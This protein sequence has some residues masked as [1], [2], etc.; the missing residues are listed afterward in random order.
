KNVAG[1]RAAFE[2]AARIRPKEPLP[3][4]YIGMTYL[5]SNDL[6]GAERSYEKALALDGSVVSAQLGVATIRHLQGRKEEAIQSYERLAQSQ[7]TLGPALNNLAYLYAE[8]GQNLERA[9]ELA[10]QAVTVAPGSGSLRDTLG[11]VLFQRG[12]PTEAIAHL[13]QAARLAPNNPTIQFHLGKALHSQGKT[14]PARTALE[15]A[16]Q[17]NLGGKDREEAESLLR[18]TPRT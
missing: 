14:N 16:L 10:E 11:W 8:T 17:G 4:I 15:K 9:Q 2:E 18:S 3:Q 12:R 5:L 6:P 13:Q 1:A 7:P